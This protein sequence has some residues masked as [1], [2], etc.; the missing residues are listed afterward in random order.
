MTAHLQGLNASQAQAVTNLSGPM[1][2]L[3]GAGTGKT[4]VITCRMVELIRNGTTPERILS[5][6]FTNKAAQEMQERT[7]NLLGKRLPTRPVV[8]TFHSLCVRILREEIEPL[9]YRKNFAIMDRG[10]QESLAREVLRQIRVTESSLKPGDL[11]SI[12]SRWKTYGLN[13]ETAAEQA[14]N[15]QEYLAALAYRRYAQKA[16]A[17]NSL[18]FDDLL[19]LTLKLF[20]TSPEAL[21]RIRQRFDHVQIDEYQDTNELQFRIVKALVESHRNLCVVGDDDQSI[22]SWRGAEVRHIL[23]FQNQFPDAKVIRL[24]DNYRCT[25]QILSAAN[26]LV[27]HNKHRHVKQLRAHK[28]A[29]HE[30]RIQ[31]FADENS[32]A[33]R[34]VLEISYLMKQRGATPGEFAILFRTNEQ[35]RVFESELRRRKIPYVLLG[36]QSFFD[37]KEVKDIVSYLRAIHSP[38]DENALLRIINTPPR[39]IG[40]ASVEKVFQRAVQTGKRFVD[41]IDECAHGGTITPKAAGAM[42]HFLSYLSEQRKL[43]KAPGA[44]VPA[45]V[46]KMLSHVGYDRELERS[47]SNPNQL[48][49]RKNSMGEFH[50]AINEYFGSRRAASLQGFLDDIS[51]G[52]SDNFGDEKQKQIERDA[53]KLLT[54]HSAKGLEFPRV[55]MVGMEEGIMP[56]KRSVEGTEGEVAEER[57]LAYVGVTRAQEQLTLTFSRTRKKWGK[58]R[59]SAPSR[60]LYELRTA[61]LNEDQGHEDLTIEIE[62]DS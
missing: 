10:D 27:A 16:Q 38:S 56:H 48:E 58:V 50:E 1:L 17:M 26:S 32:E 37:R 34:V 29:R 44:N 11:L 49:M 57:R 61:T 52:N 47:Y 28:Q 8:S 21:S 15:D 46:Q 20:R 55:Y 13:P 53:V 39:G 23:G 54:Y 4:R 7:R 33:E 5:V 19:L 36:S 59:K 60:F 12:L 14:E 18:D 3:A 31:P 9:G 42:H 43:M 51:L 22:Y 30:V 62:A 24:E 25:D 41:T 2:V 35:P 6:T 45:L 40:N